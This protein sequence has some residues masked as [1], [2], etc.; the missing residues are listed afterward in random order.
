MGLEANGTQELEINH[1]CVPEA[2][3]CCDPA[4]PRRAPS[5]R[6]RG[7]GTPTDPPSAALPTPRDR[8]EPSPP[9]RNTNAGERRDVFPLE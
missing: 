3:T 1:A 8:E 7:G 9:Q 6:A 5:E 4:K 2:V